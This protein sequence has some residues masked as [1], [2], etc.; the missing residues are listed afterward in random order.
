MGDRKLPLA[1]GSWQL[2]GSFRQS[3]DIDSICLIFARN[4]CQKSTIT[5]RSL[6]SMAKRWRLW[7]AFNIILGFGVLAGI[8]KVAPEYMQSLTAA[9]RERQGGD[10][11]VLA[12]LQEF[13][14]FVK[15][16]SE[17]AHSHSMVSRTG[18]CVNQLWSTGD[19]LSST[20]TPPHPTPP[21]VHVMPML[22][23]DA[24]CTRVLRTGVRCNPVVTAYGIGGHWL[25]GAPC[26]VHV[27]P[28]SHAGETGARA[29]QL[30]ANC[31]SLGRRTLEIE[32]SRPWKAYL[33][34]RQS[35][36]GSLR[37]TIELLLKRPFHY[38]CTVLQLTTHIIIHHSLASK[39]VCISGVWHCRYSPAP[40][41]SSIPGALE[42]CKLCEGSW[43]QGALL[44]QS[45][46]CA[47]ILHRFL[48]AQMANGEP[49]YAQLVC[50]HTTV[51]G[52][53]DRRP[54]CFV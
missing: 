20:H 52:C 41:D 31:F 15:Q 35:M 17:D 51:A 48:D 32:R 13:L 43:R 30:H 53:N 2:A 3:F 47:D 23:M 7:L 14:A 26:V 25:W 39:L 28:N 37:C 16:F 4:Q 54:A 6:P 22:P 18:N 29:L 33:Q 50:T 45:A 21:T 40:V 27:F 44:T 42:K 49:G 1:A 10:S 9:I 12:P 38:R 34:W 5:S 36:N 8:N 19:Y 11:T 46:R 24:G